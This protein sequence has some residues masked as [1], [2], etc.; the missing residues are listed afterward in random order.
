MARRIA[1]IFGDEVHFN[2]NLETYINDLQRSALSLKARMLK[3]EVEWLPRLIN[4]LKFYF[5]HWMGKED[6]D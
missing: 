6:V 2:D 3:S 1:V 5:A 4:S